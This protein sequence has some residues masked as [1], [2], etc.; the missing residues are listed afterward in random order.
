MPVELGAT[1]LTAYSYLLGMYLGDGYLS[2]TPRTYRLE[3][4]L[5]EQQTRVIDRVIR[6]ISALRAGRPVGLRRRG[7]VRI[8]S[9]TTRRTF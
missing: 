9:R 8:H 4:S 7:S 3:I 2:R 1:Q 5:H 6:P